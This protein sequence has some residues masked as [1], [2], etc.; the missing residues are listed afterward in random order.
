[1]TSIKHPSNEGLGAITLK[2]PARE[3]VIDS[4]FS[5]MDEGARAT[6][7]CRRHT[8]GCPPTLACVGQDF[9]LESIPLVLPK[10]Q[11]PHGDQLQF[12]PSWRSALPFLSLGF[13][14]SPED[15]L[16]WNVITLHLA[17]CM[18]GTIWRM[19]CD[20]YQEGKNWS[21]NRVKELVRRA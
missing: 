11:F 4:L 17:V 14:K 21:V 18:I 5:L 20:L 19:N 16:Q 12:D 9:W 10:A 3:L 15:N 2:N 7:D 8:P 13:Q 6:S 1:M